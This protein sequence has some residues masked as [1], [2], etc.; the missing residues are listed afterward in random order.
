MLPSRPKQFNRL[1]SSQ[2]ANFSPL[3]K[4][5]L[6]FLTVVVGHDCLIILLP[7]KMAKCDD[8]RQYFYTVYKGV[9]FEDFRVRIPSLVRLLLLLS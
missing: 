2:G 3:S 4:N 6:Y 1:S 8:S 9:H 7:K 5:K